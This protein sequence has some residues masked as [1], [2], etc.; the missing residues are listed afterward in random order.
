MA[1]AIDPLFFL[2][3]GIGA[4]GFGSLADQIGRRRAWLYSGVMLT[5]SS[6]ICAIAP[7]YTVYLVARVLVGVGTGG[8]GIVT[9]VLAQEIIGLSWAGK[10]GVCQ[11]VLFSIANIL[12]APTAYAFPGW[13][14][15]TAFTAVT[16]LFFL[17]FY[18]M[19]PESP[20]WLLSQGDTAAANA[21]MQLIAKGNGV[22]IPAGTTLAAV[23]QDTSED[24][25]P[26][27][28]A[29]LFEGVL[30]KRSL[31]MLFCWFVASFGYY[32]LSL[33]SGNM[34]V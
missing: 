27:G 6:M 25:E 20:R 30:L 4:S 29:Q 14:A 17:A 11:A 28:V 26:L 21:V 1:E 8:F 32:G 10:A 5:V 12:L 9:Y 19:I 23:E 34:G 15:L 33:N 3:F 24:A 13:R 2:G 22:A 31:V 16:P 7:A 18:K